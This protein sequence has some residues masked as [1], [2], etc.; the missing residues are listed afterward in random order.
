MTRKDLNEKNYK[1]VEQTLENEL[2]LYSESI[3]VID[4][5]EK[6][7]KEEQEVIKELDEYDEYL[8][9]VNYELPRECVYDGEK[10]NKNE[11]IQAIIY[12]LNK[13]EVEYQYTL[14]MYQLVK[15]WKNVDMPT[16]NYKA[17]DSTLR[18]LNGCK[19]KGYQEWRDI[20][21][22]N[23]YLSKCHE[24]YKMDLAYLIYLSTKHN[25][26]LDRMKSLNTQEEISEDIDAVM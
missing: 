9:S 3:S 23:S 20:L 1:E 12:N 5:I 21:M 2:T 24:A 14:G 18:C 17:Y 22:V 13:I 4:D 25:T 15:M 7:E 10:F 8:N 26:I 19:F 16:I 11:I 6:L